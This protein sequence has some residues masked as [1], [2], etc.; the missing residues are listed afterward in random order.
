M[1]PAILTIIIFFLC[2]L[3]FIWEKIPLAVT[4]LLGG[5]ALALLGI[6]DYVDIYSNM[7]TQ[8]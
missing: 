3:S 5:I 7:G 6:I 4:C 8:V 2:I 1:S